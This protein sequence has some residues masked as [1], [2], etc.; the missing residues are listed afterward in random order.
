[1]KKKCIIIITTLILIILSIL[2]WL[3]RWNYIVIHHSAGD[4]GNIEHLQDIHDQRQSK[5]PIHAISYH[6]II[7]NGNGME[8]GRVESDIRKKFNLWGVHVTK[9]NW[10]KN[11]RGLG[12]CIIG[13]LDKKEMTSKQYE[14]LLK[15]TLDLMEEYNIDFEN[16]GFHGKLPGE[17]TKCP[18]KFF[19]YDKLKKDIKDKI[20]FANNVYKK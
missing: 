12:I 13:N 8:D 17:S 18:G 7:G 14:S 4:Y 5:E 10:D 20:T 11:F 16:I 6:Y 19:P 3:N 1:M 2:Y 15:L 9:N